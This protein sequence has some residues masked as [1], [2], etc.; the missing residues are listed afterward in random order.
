[1]DDGDVPVYPLLSQAAQPVN[2][3]GCECFPR[4]FHVSNYNVLRCPRFRESFGNG[5]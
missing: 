2:A 5:S 1:M 3:T 4:A